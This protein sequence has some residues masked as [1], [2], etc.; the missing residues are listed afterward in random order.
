MGFRD[1]VAFNK[2]LVA[3]QG[4]RM[5]THPNSLV[6]RVFK[7]KYFPKS[8]IMNAQLGSNPS[9]AWRSI[10]WEEIYCCIE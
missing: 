1:P 9:Y 6:V 8:D 2:V 3:K 7:A 5:I 10:I 4:W